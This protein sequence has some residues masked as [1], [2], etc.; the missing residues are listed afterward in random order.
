[1]PAIAGHTHGG[2]VCIPGYG[3]IITLSA[4]PCENSSGLSR[5]HGVP[6]YVSRG[7][8][9]EGGQAPRL[10]FCCPPEVT[11]LSLVAPVTSPPTLA[12]R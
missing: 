4:L 6:L 8:G 1:M 7:I 5:Y 12:R 2:Q 9:Y 3:P 10:R 11:L